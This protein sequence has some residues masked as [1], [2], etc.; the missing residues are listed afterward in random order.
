MTLMSAFII[1]L[2]LATAWLGTAALLRKRHLR[3]VRQQRHGPEPR[4]PRP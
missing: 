4:R 2:L 3:H 1:L